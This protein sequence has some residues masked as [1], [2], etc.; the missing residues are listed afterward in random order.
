M[1]KISIVIPAYNVERYIRQCIDSILQQT[2]TNYE[3]LIVDDGSTDQTGRICDEYEKKDGRI[4]VIHQ[5]NMGQSVARNEALDVATGEFVTFIDSDDWVSED[6]LEQM[7]A[8]VYKTGADIS[9]CGLRYFDDGDTTS[10]VRKDEYQYNVTSGRNVCIDYYQMKQ[11]ITV[12]PSGKLFKADLLKD[13]RFPPG[14]IYEDQGTIPR[15]FYLAKKVAFIADSELYAYCVREM[16]TSHAPFSARK[17][18]DV[19]NV[20]YCVCFF[21]K[22][23]DQELAKLSRR[24]ETVLQAKY[25]VQ[26]YH[27]N[28]EN[29]IP[30]QY[31]MHLL[32][33]LNVLRKEIKYDTFSWY[34]SL[35]YPQWVKPYAYVHKLAVLLR[36]RKRSQ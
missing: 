36:I 4:H 19:W 7:F 10:F 8:A 30:D 16:S 11:I 6:F 15:L 24:F 17:F 2:F 25:I 35:V 29:Q 5:K 33:A 13:I 22:Q 23:G 28:I 32:A 27:F 34:L 31:R 1:P 21:S 20:N 14:K 9:V 12:G 3:V 26:A 18:E